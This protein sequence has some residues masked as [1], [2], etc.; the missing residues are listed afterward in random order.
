MTEQ[1]EKIMREKLMKEVQHFIGRRIPT[2]KNPDELLRPAGY[3]EEEWERVGEELL[4]LMPYFL[5]T[6]KTE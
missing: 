5:G 1:E 3:S 4:K 6:D 2:P